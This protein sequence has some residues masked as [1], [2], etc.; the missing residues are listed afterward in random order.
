MK[1]GE[2]VIVGNN[3]YYQS[4]I[5]TIV[6]SLIVILFDIYLQIYQVSNIYEKC[7]YLDPWIVDLLA[8]GVGIFLVID[9]F[10]SIIKNKADPIVKNYSRIIRILIGISILTL[11]V[12]Q[13]LHK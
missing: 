4:I 1:K 7:S 13:F 5:L 10:C 6:L 8:F 2:E 12:L 11:H 3:T 9:G